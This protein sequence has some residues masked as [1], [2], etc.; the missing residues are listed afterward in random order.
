MSDDAKVSVHNGFDYDLKFIEVHD[1]STYPNH[2]VLYIDAGID[3][4]DHDDDET[5]KEDF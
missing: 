3:P 5:Y 1:H 4:P 2:L